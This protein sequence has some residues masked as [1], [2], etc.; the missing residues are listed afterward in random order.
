MELGN[1]KPYINPYY[2]RFTIF[3]SNYIAISNKIF[4]M[5]RF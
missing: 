3:K 4:G 2:G 1:Y 5:I